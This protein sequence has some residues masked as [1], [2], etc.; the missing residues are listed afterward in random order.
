MSL[1]GIAAQQHFPVPQSFRAVQRAELP[2][3]I[4]AA[5]P[6]SILRQSFRRSARL[7]HRSAGL[8]TI[9]RRIRRAVSLSSS[10]RFFSEFFAESHRPAVLG[11]SCAGDASP[12]GAQF[13]NLASARRPRPQNGHPFEGFRGFQ[14]CSGKAVRL[15]YWAINL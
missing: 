1:T 6:G 4:S 8:A 13:S 7:L 14:G 2:E 15:G 3:G 9:L 10:R 5:R 12:G 11:E